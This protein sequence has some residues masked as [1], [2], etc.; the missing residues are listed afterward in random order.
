[1]TEQWYG[2][3]FRTPIKVMEPKLKIKKKIFSHIGRHE[4]FVFHQN[5]DWE[6]RYKFS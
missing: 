6:V 2:E 4:K 3:G 5:E 1:M